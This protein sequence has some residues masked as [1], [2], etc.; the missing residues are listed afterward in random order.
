MADLRVPFPE[1]LPELDP[2]ITN[3]VSQFR[4]NAAALA[5]APKPSTPIPVAAPPP[6]PRPGISGIPKGFYKG[7]VSGAPQLVGEALQAFGAD[8]TGRSIAEAAKAR[9]EAIGD[10]GEWGE[11]ASML[12]PALGVG[13]TAFIPGVGQVAAPALG[14]ALFGGAQYTQTREKGG[15]VGQALGTAAVQGV[16]Q[17]VAGHV[18]GKVLTGAGKMVMPAT[19]Q[20]VLDTFARPSVIGRTIANTAKAAA[21]QVPTQMAAMGGVAAIEEGLPDTPD[22]WNAAK[23]SEIGR[24]HV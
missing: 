17:A 5:A 18:A 20:G 4:A 3:F 21:I 6:P 10:V 19:A 1:A 24:A 2:R 12:V 22:A 9:G 15:T 23:E 16:G 8:E 11:A 13:A 7:L 14:A